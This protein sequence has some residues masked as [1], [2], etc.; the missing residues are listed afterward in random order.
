MSLQLLPSGGF[1]INLNGTEIKGQYSAASLKK[2]SLMNGGI[3]FSDTIS[4]LTDNAS[5]SSFLQ[6]VLCATEG[7]Y[8]EFDVL[9]WIE[10]LGGFDSEDSQKL[11]AHFMDGF[12]NK[13]KVTE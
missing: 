1:L 7:N 6:L 4:L 10:H 9:E 2:F 8:T 5:I 12:V 13:K 11:F 3:G